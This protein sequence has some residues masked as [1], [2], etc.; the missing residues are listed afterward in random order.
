MEPEYFPACAEFD[1]HMED[2][3]EQEFFRQMDWLETDHHAHVDAA[4]QHHLDTIHAA[5]VHEWFIH[6]D[7]EI[8]F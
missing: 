3:A 7:W 5:H 1:K 4:H 6:G 2:L 8:P